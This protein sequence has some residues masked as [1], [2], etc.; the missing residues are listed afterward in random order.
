ME[1]IDVWSWHTRYEPR[2]RSE[3]SDEVRDGTHWSLTLAHAGLRVESSGA[4]G[5]P[6]ATSLDGSVKFDAFAE[7]VSRLT[8]GYAFR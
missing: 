1:E 5:R 2:E 8:G 4:D 7:A 6:G 3:P